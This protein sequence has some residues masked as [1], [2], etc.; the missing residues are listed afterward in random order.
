M[1]L[2][3][4]EGILAQESVQFEKGLKGFILAVGGQGDKA[5]GKQVEFCCF[6]VEGTTSTANTPWIQKICK[7]K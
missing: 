6:C 2:I 5:K 1:A 3:R 4:G 7:Q